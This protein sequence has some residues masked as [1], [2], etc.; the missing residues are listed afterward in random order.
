MSPMRSFNKAEFRLRPVTMASIPKKRS[1]ADMQH[2]GEASSQEFNDTDYE[3][4]VLQLDGTCETAVDEALMREATTFGVDLSQTFI[5]S[6]K[7]HISICDSAAT[8]GSEHIRTSSMES[9]ASAS[10][11]ITSISSAARS[12]AGVP[13]ITRKITEKRPLPFS[14]YDRFLAQLDALEQARIEA[15]GHIASSKRAP[16]IFSVSTQKSYNGLRS[17]FKSH[18]KLRRSKASTGDLM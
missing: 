9:E 3:R 18:F 7:G 5:A 1:L 4:E 12:T 11:G 6:Q 2:T 16:S 10:T 13:P 14:A 17:S 15:L 8:V